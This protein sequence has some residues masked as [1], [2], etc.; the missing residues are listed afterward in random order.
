EYGSVIEDKADALKYGHD[1]YPDYWEMFSIEVTG[2][3][4]CGG[5]YT[6]L[7]ATYFKANSG[8]LFDWGMTH[9]EAT[10]PVNTDIYFKTEVE[11]STGGVDHFGIGMSLS[12]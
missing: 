7:A 11:V 6:F 4:C 3:G 12:W 1:F 10:L 2:D 8:S 9:I 5:S